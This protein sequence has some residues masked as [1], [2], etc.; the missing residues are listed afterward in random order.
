VLSVK[1]ARD[2]CQAIEPGPMT[3]RRPELF[4]DL[5]TGGKRSR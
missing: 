1:H 5:L 3:S 2:A 4:T